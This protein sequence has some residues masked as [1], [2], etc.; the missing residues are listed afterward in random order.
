[1]DNKIVFAVLSI[2]LNAYG[3][4]Q[5]LQGRTKEGIVRIILGFVTAGVVATI[6]SIFGIIQGI[7]VLKMTDEEFAAAKGSLNDGWPTLN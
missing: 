1:M 6:N 2:V 3:V 4:P 5:F 7:K